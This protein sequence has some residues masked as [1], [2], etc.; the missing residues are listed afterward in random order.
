M[1]DT[2]KSQY[3]QIPSGA[4]MSVEMAALA[5]SVGPPPKYTR[6]FQGDTKGLRQFK[7]I[8][9]DMSPTEVAAAT[10][11]NLSIVGDVT[12]QRFSK[13]LPANNSLRKVNRSSVLRNAP[14]LGT[15][16][17]G[18]I[19][20]EF[21]GDCYEVIQFFLANFDGTINTEGSGS[22]LTPTNHACDQMY[23][24]VHIFVDRSGNPIGFNRERGENG[25]VF[26]TKHMT[27][28]FYH[29]AAAS[30]GITVE[31]LQTR[32]APRTLGR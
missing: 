24:G 15:C 12:M 31:E 26:Q 30:T 27:T 25:I 22:F 13:N 2:W 17:F 20:G 18:E 11:E 6:W 8:T 19:V 28:A 32:I 10:K 9:P 29:I 4:N 23:F 3:N 21:N 1:H 16:K 14:H 7:P 5:N